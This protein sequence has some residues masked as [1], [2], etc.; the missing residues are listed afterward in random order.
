MS[1][2]K[3]VLSSGLTIAT[4]HM[5]GIE[6]ATISILAKTG[7]RNETTKLNGISHFLEHMAFKGTLTRTAKQIAEEF[8]DIGG[9]FNAYT[10]R[11]KTVYYAKVLKQDLEV[12]VDIL[13]DILQNSTLLDEEIEKER[14]VILQ[15]IAQTEDIP[16][17]LIFDHFQET[18]YPNQAFGRSI[19]GTKEFV[20][21]VSRD[22]LAGYIQDNYTYDNT[23]IAGAGNFDVAHF[24]ELMERK[25]SNL[26]TSLKKVQ[27]EVK[28]VGGDVRINK[29]LEQV[30][31]VI[32]YKGVSYRDP[33]FYAQQVL[34]LIAGGGMS[35]RL[36]QEIRE[37]RGLA[38]SVSS[39]GSSYSDSG[40]FGIYA[41]LNENQV[42][43]CVDVIGQEV[44]K[45]TYQ[46]NDTELKRAKA[47]VRAGLL[48]SQE[49]SVSRAEKLAGNFA[50]HGR[51]IDTNEILEKIDAI[52]L[53][54]V[55]SIAKKLFVSQNN[56]TVASIGKI[57]GIY[58]YDQIM[59]KLKV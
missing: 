30:H 5:D 19:L 40:I 44:A 37:N 14:G 53:N 50:V 13:A 7:S 16:D 12:A 52:D 33:E 31:L 55:H 4:D 57:K 8:D 38:Y 23:I 25:F 34:S 56:I 21:T 15:E 42:N 22:D 51:Y 27:E 24:N 6:T 32:G 20:K 29:D 47:Q 18:A 28:Y 36:F 49:S 26:N 58:E 41:G 1:I 43:E 45:L 46:I 35:S 2:Q 48:M 3:N 17:D 11:E 59:A 39:F 9:Y 54:A 10:A